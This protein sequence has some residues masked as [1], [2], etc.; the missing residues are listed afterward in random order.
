MVMKSS[1]PPIRFASSPP[2]AEGPPDESTFVGTFPVPA[3]MI[4]PPPDPPMAPAVVVAP[5]PTAM[6]VDPAWVRIWLRTQSRDFASLAVIGSSKRYPDAALQVA[7]GLARVSEELGQPV[8]VQDARAIA[9]RDL[10]GAKGRIRALAQSGQRLV[11]ALAMP[12]ENPL[13]VAL[14]QGIDVAVMCVVL[15]ESQTIV[16]QQAVEQIGRSKF[17]GSVLVRG[18]L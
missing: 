3:P 11:M 2:R 8:V 7:K 5:E 17:V 6:P 16:G 1:P 13:T 15:G 9:L 18:D 10:V 12:Q 4:Q 14:A